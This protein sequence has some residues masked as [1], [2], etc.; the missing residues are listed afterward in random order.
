MDQQKAMDLLYNADSIHQFLLIYLSIMKK[1]LKSTLF[2]HVIQV[3]II[4]L[5]GKLLIN[6]Q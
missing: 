6:L 2:I 5:L 3:Y 1:A 4:L